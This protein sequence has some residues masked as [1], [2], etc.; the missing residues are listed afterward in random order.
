MKL[1][2]DLL[3]VGFSFQESLGFL[4]KL[5]HHLPEN[6]LFKRMQ[7]ILASGEE[8][9]KMFEVTNFNPKVIGRMKLSEVHGN[10]TRTLKQT[11]RQMAEEQQRI[12]KLRQLLQYPL[13][14]VAMLFLIVCIMK[15]ILFPRMQS[16]AISDKVIKN[17]QLLDEITMFVALGII[18]FSGICWLLYRYYL[19]Q[20]A[21]KKIAIILKLPFVKS[22]CKYT[23]TSY[24]CFEW[25]QLLQ[26]GIETKEIINLLQTEG[27]LFWMKEI[28]KVI[29]KSM[30][31]GNSLAIA[32]RNCPCFL[33][34]LG[35]LINEGEAKGKL[36]LELEF[37]G[38][39]LW[40][41]WLLK[42]EMWL[43][44]VQ[45]IIFIIIGIIIISIYAAI[46]LP[47]YQFH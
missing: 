3:S 28:A 21:M 31:Q 5:Y 2:S 17:Q 23:Y 45:P 38:L 20:P 42:L 46:L 6:F 24:F 7:D 26:L 27:N 47:M 36:A 33:E 13:I 32:V 10:V 8:L 37:Y 22:W 34:G 16:L 39:E 44:W 25:S 41:E 12:I 18:F 43:Q 19:R 35:Y 11:S 1:L 15:Y 4:Q 30:E 14:L 9:H 29:E 40:Q